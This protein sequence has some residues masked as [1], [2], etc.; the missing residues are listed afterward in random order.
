MEATPVSSTH[1][2]DAHDAHAGHGHAA[3]PEEKDPLWL[4]KGLV[5]AAATALFLWAIFRVG[6]PAG[7]PK[8]WTA[9]PAS[10]PWTAGAPGHGGGH[11]HGDDAG[12][13][14]HMVERV[15]PGSIPVRFPE[16]GV[17]GALLAFVT[18]PARAVDKETW[19]DFDRLVFVTGSAAIRPDSQDQLAAIA[20][21][22]RAFP[23]VK[24]KV[25]GYTD[26]VGDPASNQRLSEE[27]AANVRG[28]LVN[29][30][31][32]ADRLAAEGYGERFPVG[33]NATPEGRARNR[34]ISMRVTDK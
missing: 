24:L 32:A 1:S 10:A 20:E 11:G 31:V 13:L 21:I 30:G 19:F 33:D 29:L 18:D 26:N 6:M 23:K 15:L 3:A 2:H 17:E 14:G 34:R 25:G 5:M 7:M 12:P 9:P 16:K 28:A 4:L 27:R 22:L 8:G